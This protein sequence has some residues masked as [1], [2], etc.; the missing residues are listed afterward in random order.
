[1]DGCQI[2]VERVIWVRDILLGHVVTSLSGY[3]ISKV[4]KQT[5]QKSLMQWTSESFRVSDL[6]SS[7][8]MN[9]F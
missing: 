5:G 7:N 3:L 2:V 8:L 9:F 1:M 6:H 4:K